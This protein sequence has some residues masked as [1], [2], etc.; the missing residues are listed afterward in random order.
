MPKYTARTFLIKDV[1]QVILQA[2]RELVKIYYPPIST[3]ALS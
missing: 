2:V 3:K 1:L